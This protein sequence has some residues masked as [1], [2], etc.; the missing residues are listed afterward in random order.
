M[1]SNAENY[2]AIGKPYGKSLDRMFGSKYFI[3]TCSSLKGLTQ[4]LKISKC[5]KDALFDWID[6]RKT[7]QTHT[8]FLNPDTSLFGNSLITF[9]RKSLFFKS[10][11]KSDITK[12]KDIWDFQ[13]NCFV[14]DRLIYTKLVDTRKWIME[15][16]TLKN[17]HIRLYKTKCKH[18]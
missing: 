18:M 8:S 9:R 5:Y 1:N 2:H 15:W 10:F 3:C 12:L 17:M 14:E 13:G 11:L 6:F 4:Q 16:T 7:L